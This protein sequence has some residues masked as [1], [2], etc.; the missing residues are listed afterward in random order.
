MFG[1][2]VGDPEPCPEG[3]DTVD[4][5]EIN[6][7]GV[8]SRCGHGPQALVWGRCRAQCAYPTDRPGTDEDAA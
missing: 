6:N 3:R 8:C 5:S 4:P 7:W 1:D 2:T